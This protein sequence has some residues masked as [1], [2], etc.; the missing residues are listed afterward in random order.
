MTL[1]PTIKKS[2]I[3]TS[4]QMCNHAYAPYSNFFVGATI[5]TDTGKI[6]KGCNVE[7]ASYGLTICAERNAIFNAVATEGS[8]MQI[9]V[10]VVSSKTSSSCSPCGACRQ[11][12]AEFCDDN[13]II[14]YKN[15]DE[16]IENT[17][18]DLLPNNFKFYK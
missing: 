18:L 3:E 2:M 14:I 8:K 12:I 15:D 9:K 7:N 10:V 17:I 16:Y 6:Y 4:E 11:V 5:L 1:D 13:S